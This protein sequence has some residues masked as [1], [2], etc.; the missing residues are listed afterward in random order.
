M[1]GSRTGS[2]AA[3]FIA[4]I[5]ILFAAAPAAAQVELVNVGDIAGGSTVFIFRKGSKAAPRS[6]ASRRPPARTRANR[7][8]TARKFTK[9]YVALAKVK[10]R[11]QRV[12]PVD[13]DD[14]RLTKWKTMSRT[15]ASKLF[16]GVG[17]YYVD[18]D[19]FDQAIEFFR[20]SLQLDG[21]NNVAVR[22][23]SEAL[24]IKGNEELARDPRGVAKQFFA[25]ALQ[26]DPR[27]APAYFGLAEIASAEDKNDEARVNYEK[28]LNLDPALTEIYAPLGI[29]YARSGDMAKA[30]T[31]LNKAITVLPDD[32][33]TQ[34]FLGLVRMSEGRFSDAL[35]AFEQA[36]RIA[37]NYADA[38]AGA[39]SAK[40]MLQRP[41]DAYADLA[42]ATQLKP[43]SFESWVGLGSA[44]FEAGR[45][46]DAVIAYEAA[47]KL[48]NNDADAFED[49]GDAYRQAGS[50]EKAESAYRNAAMFL[51]RSPNGD[52]ET[53]ADIYNKAAFM[54]GRQCEARAATGALCRWGD[55][56]SYIEKT[57]ALSRTGV[58]NS[59]L[60][61]AYLNAAIQDL[62]FRNVDIA[63][64]K[65]EKAKQAL[66]TAA[67][68]GGQV[69]A[70]ALLN[71][72]R[73]LSALGDQAGAEKAFQ[74]AL[75]REPGWGY[76][77]NEL[78]AVYR[79]Q[80]RIAEALEWFKKAAAAQPQDG[81]ILFNLGEAQYQLGKFGD[82]NDTYS[83]LRKLGPSAKNWADRLKRLGG[84]RLK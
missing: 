18:R 79:K 4:G 50:F 63:R 41:A 7:T 43:D 53:A 25:E 80:D 11:R 72:G 9:Q 67:R 21:K 75:S 64:P 8:D 62:S 28:A 40:L 33:D 83:R 27:N 15:D 54:V 65:L 52:K 60:G 74:Q 26:Y 56:I 12:T 19:S 77:M 23:L 49:L 47:I 44:A 70:G 32:A 57:A 5:V 30:D 20:E 10:P 42:R 36:K 78:G 45:W 2:I 22:G 37:P 76:A 66:L 69:S 13:P 35:A 71:L 38:Y 68:D 16:A 61:W 29:L 73:T 3:V 51:E 55:A 46:Q 84:S 59:N 24:A 17:E 14:P 6:T 1:S 31:M 34:Y 48:R 82:A 81:V 39:G 58:D